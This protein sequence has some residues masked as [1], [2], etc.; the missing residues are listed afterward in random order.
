MES[1]EIDLNNLACTSLDMKRV[2][3]K[4]DLVKNRLKSRKWQSSK[5]NFFFEKKN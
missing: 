2:M 1:D 4:S 5:L 3:S